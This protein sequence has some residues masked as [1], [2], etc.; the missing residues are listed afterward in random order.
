MKR[1]I[2]FSLIAM[3]ATNFA[4]A[5][6]Y[7]TLDTISS[8]YK[9]Y[10]YPEWYDECPTFCTDSARFRPSYMSIGYGT[11]LRENYTPR[12]LSVK[13]V[14]VMVV[15]EEWNPNYPPVDTVRWPQYVSIYQWDP[16]QP[17][18]LLYLDSARWDTV[19]PKVMR[20]PAICDSAKQTNPTFYPEQYYCY[21]YECRFKNPIT[22]DSFFYIGST[23]NGCDVTVDMGYGNYVSACLRITY[24]AMQPWDNDCNIRLRKAYWRP[25]SG[26]P[27]FYEPLDPAQ[28]NPYGQFLAIVDNHHLNV[29]SSDTLM[30]SVQGS[31]LFPDLSADTIIAI[32]NQNCRFISWNDGNTDNPRV[33]TL[34]CDTSFTAIFDS[35]ACSVQV[36]ANKDEWGSV[37][38]SGTYYTNSTVTISATP[39]DKYLF[40]RWDDGGW[41]NPRTFTLTQDTAFTA[42]FAP[43]PSQIGIDEGG[44]EQSLTVSPNPVSGL[45]TVSVGNGNIRTFEIIDLR[46]TTYKQDSFSGPTATLDISS[47]PTGTY[48]V[49]VSTNNG[50]AYKKLVVK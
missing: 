25:H 31:G 43:D 23:N 21:V 5:Q 8:R 19:T 29:Y 10:Y 18:S 48:I 11:F 26:F 4:V 15:R 34:V 42:I 17:D 2:A 22:V 46:G 49:R 32:P 3:L 7:G 14:A 35:G 13:G 38:G 47:L 44:M 40:D 33:I 1:I 37:S 45:L 16:S 39:A 9:D 36:F 27:W 50:T 28:Y 6:H 24:F 30:G 12:P 20:L 41:Q